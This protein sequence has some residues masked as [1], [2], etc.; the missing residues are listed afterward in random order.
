MYRDCAAS[1]SSSYPCR[2]Q[3][4]RAHRD[5]E[6]YLHNHGKLDHH[7]QPWRTGYIYAALFSVLKP[8]PRKAYAHA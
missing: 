5:P 6:Q 1:K 8:Q 3:S 2:L 4:V 7:A